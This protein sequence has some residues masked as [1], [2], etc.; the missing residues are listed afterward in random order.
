MSNFVAIDFKRLNIKIQQYE[1]D[2][3]F[4]VFA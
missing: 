3:K 1:E 4:S 2:N